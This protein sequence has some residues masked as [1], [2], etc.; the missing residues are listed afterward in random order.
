DEEGVEPAHFLE[1]SPEREHDQVAILLTRVG[2]QHGRVDRQPVVGH[3]EEEAAILL[4]ELR[5]RLLLDRDEAAP[6]FLDPGWLQLS[7]NAP[8]EVNPL[9]Y[10]NMVGRVRNRKGSR[11]RSYS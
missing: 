8:R 2:V 11:G 5:Q 7:Q 3:R 6:V 4:A 10:P 9:F 1:Q